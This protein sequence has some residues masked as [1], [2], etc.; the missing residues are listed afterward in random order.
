MRQKVGSNA[1]RKI[2]T[3]L[4]LDFVYR[5]CIANEVLFAWVRTLPRGG[6]RFARIVPG[7]CLGTPFWLRV[8]SE[9]DDLTP[10]YAHTHV[11]REVSE[12]FVSAG[13]T[14]VLALTRATAVRGR[15]PRLDGGPPSAKESIQRVIVKPEPSME[16]EDEAERAPQ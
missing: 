12:G 15:K 1:W 7:G 10:R 8:M 6:G 14:E 13:L 5:W 16:I 9:F 2:T 11:P 3:K 4:P